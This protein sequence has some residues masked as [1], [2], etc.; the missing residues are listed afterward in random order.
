M[1]I[2]ETLQ[3][4]EWDRFLR[5]EAEAGNEDAIE[6]LNWMKKNRWLRDCATA[7]RLTG[8]QSAK[9]QRHLPPRKT[10]SLTAYKSTFL[11]GKKPDIDV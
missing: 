4:E 9:S 2:K 6:I 11:Q 5:Q 8:A 7:G 10:V 3:S 1:S